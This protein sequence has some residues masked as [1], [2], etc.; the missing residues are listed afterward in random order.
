M[1]QIENKLQDGRF[2]AN[3]FDSYIQSNWNNLKVQFVDRDQA[4]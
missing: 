3:H 2:K 1:E 4:D